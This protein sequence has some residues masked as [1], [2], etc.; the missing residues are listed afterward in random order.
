MEVSSPS[1]NDSED[2][3]PD[4][5]KLVAF[6]I[7]PIVVVFVLIWVI[8][9][10]WMS[11]PDISLKDSTFAEGKVDTNWKLVAVW[12]GV[13]LA[14]V[15]EML[16]EKTKKFFKGKKAETDE[17][18]KFFKIMKDTSDAALRA[19][20]V[21]VITSS[22]N[23]IVHYMIVRVLVGGFSIFLREFIIPRV[24]EREWV[25]WVSELWKQR[26]N[27]NYDAVSPTDT[28][29]DTMPQVQSTARSRFAAL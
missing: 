21:L 3:K 11:V 10:E 20:D 4:W 13:V 27:N 25:K 15:A 2:S 29:T 26:K 1:T 24:S 16:D 5:L 23:M 28:D 22:F 7:V 6:Q 14:S 12:G 8:D 17:W 9:P 19:F 18:T